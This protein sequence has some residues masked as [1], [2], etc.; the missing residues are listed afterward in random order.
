MWAKESEPL[1]FLDIHPVRRAD[2]KAQT[3]LRESRKYG[4]MP[5]AQFLCQKASVKSARVGIPVDKAT[6]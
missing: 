3:V 5:I 6:E 1:L 2:G 4:P